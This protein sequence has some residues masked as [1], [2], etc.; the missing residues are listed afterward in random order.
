MQFLAT[1]RGD[2]TAL[3]G[4]LAQAAAVPVQTVLVLGAAGNGWDKA[5]LAERLGR[6]PQAVC[7]ALFPELIVH[8]RRAAR[9]A[10]VLPLEGESKVAFLPLGNAAEAALR[11][12]GLDSETARLALLFVPA[13]VEGIAA[14]VE[15]VFNHLGPQVAY[16][17]A[18]AGGLV[19]GAPALFGNAGYVEGHALICLSSLT[20]S[21]GVA[22]G[23]QPVS[24]PLRV[25]RAQGHRILGLDWRPA[26]AVYRA[27]VAG[28]EGAGTQ[29]ATDAYPLGVA[30]LG[31]EMMVRDVVGVEEGA[32]VCAAELSEGV[33]V[34]VLH[35]SPA[36]L[37][38]AAA[39]ARQQAY[40]ARGQGAALPVVVDCV[41]RAQFLGPDYARELALLTAGEPLCGALTLGEIASGG[42]DCLEFL[43][44][45]AVLGLLHG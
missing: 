26:D 7:G 44:K 41:S 39:A 43:N 28:H 30:R 37:L 19:G 5:A 18:G 27:A 12:T 38:T 25:T 45:T 8:G 16:L 9:G 10:L 17:G 13:T 2:L 36:L 22:H 32:V 20:A 14:L 24:P 33:Y 6:H 15:A 4:L 35:A 34:H 29:A 23:W 3:D 31:A 42:H 21:V 11:L 1:E 40:A